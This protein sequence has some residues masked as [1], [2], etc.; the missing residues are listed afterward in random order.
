MMSLADALIV[1]IVSLWIYQPPC[2]C[3][4]TGSGL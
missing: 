2:G 1:V 4:W 3:S